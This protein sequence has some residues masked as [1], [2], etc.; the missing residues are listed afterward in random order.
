MKVYLA[1][2]WAARAS[3][4]AIAA[5]L[6]DAGHVITE[7]WWTYPN[8]ADPAVLRRGATRNV[9]GVT[10]ADALLL[11]NSQRR[12]RETSGKAVET[13]IAVGQRK[14]VLLVGKPSNIF[15]YLPDVVVVPT[16]DDAIL[17]LACVG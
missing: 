3:M 8:T 11:V 15:H 2:P 6:A 10:A 14:P 13:G 4:P 9:A 16:V 1:A 17:A 7:P 12:G 5:R